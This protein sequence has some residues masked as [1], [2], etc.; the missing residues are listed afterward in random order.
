MNQERLKNTLELMSCLLLVL[1]IAFVSAAGNSLTLM[2]T[3]AILLGISAFCVLTYMTYRFENHSF[4]ISIIKCEVMFLC[5][6]YAFSL[7]IHEYHHLIVGIIFIIIGIL[8]I[9]ED[10]AE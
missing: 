4:S 8:M 7:L 6:L 9:Q 1:E 5:A 10:R 2:H 3:I